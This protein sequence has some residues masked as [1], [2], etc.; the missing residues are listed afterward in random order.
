[1][2]ADARVDAVWLFG[3]RARDETDDLSDVDLALLA[4]GRPAV[5]EIERCRLEWLSLACA[6]I[7]SDEV[8]LLVLNSAPV[9]IRHGALRTARLLWARR[10][11]LAADF[12]AKTVKEWLD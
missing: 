2:A 11:E 7:G 1:L 10:P 6:E 4:H 9:A 12:A 8:S 5:A 3:S